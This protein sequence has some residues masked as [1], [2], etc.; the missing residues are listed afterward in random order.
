MIKHLFILALTLLLTVATAASPSPKKVA[1]LYS[2]KTEVNSKTI[3]FMIKQFA[4]S[5][6]SYQLVPVQDAKAIQPGAYKAILVLNTGLKSGINPG[7]AGFIAGWKK[8]S[9]IVLITLHKDSR[10]INVES[11]PASPASLGVDGITAASTWTGRGF[12]SMFGGKNNPEYDMHVEW[13]NRVI[14]L[15]NDIH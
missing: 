3:H 8:K 12:T 11:I 1:I 5:G 15:V 13:V 9:E 2:G 14:A 4:S 6:S 10:K 7:L